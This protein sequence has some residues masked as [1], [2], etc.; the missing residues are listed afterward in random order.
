MEHGNSLHPIRDCA[1]PPGDHCLPDRFRHVHN[2]PFKILSASAIIPR[3]FK[4]RDDAL[5]YS[6]IQDCVGKQLLALLRVVYKTLA[7]VGKR[8]TIMSMLVMKESEYL[9]SPPVIPPL[10]LYFMNIPGNILVG[11]RPF[12]D[13]KNRVNYFIKDVSLR[14]VC[15]G[16]LHLGSS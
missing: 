7:R 14:D 12:G 4:E 3:S 10:A 16:Y 15:A 9:P 6:G 8:D 13:G 1:E 5:K 11:T 2:E